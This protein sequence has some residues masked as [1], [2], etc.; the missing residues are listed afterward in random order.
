MGRF[1]FFFVGGFLRVVSAVG[2]GVSN[3]VSKARSFISDF[4]QAGVDLIAGMIQGVI[5]KAKDLAQ[6]AWDAAKG[7][8]NAAKSALGIKSPS[9]EFKSLGMFSMI[10][11]GN[12]IAQYANKAAKESRLAATKV[13]DAFKVDL[14]P[15][16]T[17]G[18]GGSLNGDVNAHMSKDVKH[19]LEENNKPIVNVLVRNEGD[20][21]WIKSTIEELG[22][23]E[24]IG[25]NF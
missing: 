18:L 5:D 21:E 15:G 17:E 13:M 1:F 10:G 20:S 4:A 12:G 3:A 11:L 9:R 22:A 6:A 8:L 2:Q 23:R 19:S 14:S 24:A 25:D 16:I 7:A